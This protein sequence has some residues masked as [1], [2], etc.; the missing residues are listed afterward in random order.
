MTTTP[1]G[2]GSMRDDGLE[3]RITHGALRTRI[4]KV[5][6]CARDRDH[7]RLAWE[8]EQLSSSLEE[9]LA[10][11]SSVLAQLPEQAAKELRAGQER[12][13]STVRALHVG[14]DAGCAACDRESLAAEL[15]TLFAFQDDAERRGFRGLRSSW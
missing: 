9:H 3:P 2:Y 6:A 13:R 10:V 11:E 8:L 7:R 14:L 5:R 15:D 4:K 12:I 1:G